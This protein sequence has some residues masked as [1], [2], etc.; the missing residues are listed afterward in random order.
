MLV[1]HTSAG[2]AV[3]SK[4]GNFHLAHSLIM[5][6]LSAMELDIRNSRVLAELKLK[7]ALIGR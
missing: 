2:D 6:V 4:I 1:I 5:G 7:V 3:A